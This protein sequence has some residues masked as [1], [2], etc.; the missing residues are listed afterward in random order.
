MR[1]GQV[2]IALSE[3][4]GAFVHE[5]AVS[6]LKEGLPETE[7]VTWTVPQKKYHLGCG[8]RQGQPG[9]GDLA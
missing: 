1:Q 3:T 7:A 6:I 4:G 5:Y 9:G 8:W 2:L